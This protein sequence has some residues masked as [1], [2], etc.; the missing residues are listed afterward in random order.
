MAPP[1]L[2]IG[3]SRH[4]TDTPTPASRIF[5]GPG[6][7][8]ALVEARGTYPRRPM[9]LTPAARLSDDGA[10][11]SQI[12]HACHGLTSVNSG[13]FLRNSV[14]CCETIRPRACLRPLKRLDR[15][16]NRL[17]VTRHLYLAPRL[18]NLAVLVDKEGGAFDAHIGLAV[19]LFLRPY[20]IGFEHR[21]LLV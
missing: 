13:N 6:R 15:L 17:G 21:L 4:G 10:Q 9:G 14:A 20:P 8:R 11:L 18:G 12:G 1:S 5:A 16:Q 7:K 2:G 3:Q 19:H